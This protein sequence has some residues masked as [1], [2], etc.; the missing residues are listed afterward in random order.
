[1]NGF[2]NGYTK[3][4]LAT[5]MMARGIDIPNNTIVVNFSTPLSPTGG[6]CYKE[7]LLRVSRAGRFGRPGSA[8]TLIESQSEMPSYCKVAIFLDLK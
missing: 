2:R 6:P 1:M 7:Y 5:N 4:I 3:V 8:L